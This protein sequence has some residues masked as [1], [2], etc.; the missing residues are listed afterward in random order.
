MNLDQFK[1]LNEKYKFG[2]THKANRPKSYEEWAEAYKRIDP[3]LE[4]EMP[5]AIREAFPNEA[6]RQYE[7]R[8]KNHRS[9]TQSKLNQ[10]IANVKRI[11]MQG[12]FSITWGDRMG[13]WAKV[14][15]FEG[16]EFLSF[17][18]NI[19]YPFRVGDP[20]GIIAVIPQDVAF[21]G[22]FQD[23]RI[24][25]EKRKVEIELFEFESIRV[26]KKDMIVIEKENRILYVFQPNDFTIVYLRENPSESPSIFEFEHTAGM[27]AY[28]L[29]GYPQYI[30]DAAENEPRVYFVSDFDFAVPAMDNLERL[31]NMQMSSFLPGAFPTRITK[32]MDCNECG[33]KGEVQKRNAD[34]SL[35]VILEKDELNGNT[36]ERD[37]W[38]MCGA[39]KGKGV[40]PMSP[41]DNINIPKN[42]DIFG[43][44]ANNLSNIGNAIMAYVSPSVDILKLQIDTVKEANLECDRVLN[45]TKQSNQS[46]SGAAKE[47]DR[48]GLYTQLK[49]IADS[50]K[51]LM[52]KIALDIINIRITS[53]Q[54]KQ[55][56]I[57][58]FNIVT[59]DDYA[60]RSSEEV[61]AAMLNNIDKK[62]IF[63]RQS[64]YVEYLNAEYKMMPN[65]VQ[66]A[67]LA[68]KIT[69]GNVRRTP[70][71]LKNLLLQNV[72]TESD[73]RKAINSEA[74]ILRLL[75]EE[76]T[77]QQIITELDA[78]IAALAP[79]P[80]IPIIP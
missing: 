35:C 74:I 29:G 37:E 40:A 39:C 47:K 2:Q 77:E 76:K 10:A 22:E 38:I 72:I 61:Q 27:L 31:N 8:K 45:I 46:E 6:L 49:G 20:N 52:A 48:E 36:W 14:A 51:N 17:F 41:L 78:I 32:D 69:N 53:T 15:T 60:L 75:D 44:D 43:K 63:V 9:Q 4:G 66:A 67:K 55:Q 3:H 19:V 59:N 65:V 18:F 5:T 50:M 26:F 58:A 13:E 62:P 34:G 1:A 42:T 56:E 70:E 79:A 68:F 71:E 25:A 12:S 33:G 23:P 57:D 11:V 28:P 16:F 64:E 30:E 80:P 21:D 7:W 54:E 73:V 24:L